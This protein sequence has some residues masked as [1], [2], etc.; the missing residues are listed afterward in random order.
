MPEWD[1]DVVIDE[2]LVRAL[3]EE[4]FPELRSHSVQLAGEGCDNSVWVDRRGVG[5]SLPPPR[6]GG[7]ARAPASSRCCR[8]WPRSSRHLFQSR[9]S[10]ARRA[11]AFPG[12]FSAHRLLTG[13][14]LGDAGLTDDRSR[15]P[16]RGAS[17]TSFGRST[18]PRRETSST[19]GELCRLIR[20]D[21]RTCRFA[22]RRPE[23]G[24]AVSPISS[25]NAGEWRSESSLTLKGSGRARHEVLVHGDLHVRHVLVDNGE[26]S[27]VID[28]GD[29]CVGD[30]G[31]RPAARLECRPSRSRESAPSRRTGRSTTSRSAS[32]CARDLALCRAHVVR[33]A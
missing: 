13:V 22:S 25:L 20:I 9:L 28:W 7:A 24:S 31:D 10:S 26:L 2:A 3:L 16:R 15:S 29:V 33:T 11:S 14:E 5:V 6:A 32:S 19:T 4:Q 23:T 1:P 17:P 18:H 8:D 21:A 30:P 12:R 27:G